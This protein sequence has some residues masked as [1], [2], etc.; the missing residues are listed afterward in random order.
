VNPKEWWHFDYKDWKQ[1]AIQNA[2]FEDL[3]R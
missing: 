3:G 1:Y 2:K